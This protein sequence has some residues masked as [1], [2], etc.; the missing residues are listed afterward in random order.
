MMHK[1][2]LVAALLI[3]ACGADQAVAVGDSSAT[4]DSAMR[5]E[6]KVTSAAGMDA[7]LIIGAAGGDVMQAHYYPETI[8][9]ARDNM[10][11]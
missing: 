2:A 9:W 7:L 5:T 6:W 11:A 4:Q 1:F 10:S 3:A 8:A